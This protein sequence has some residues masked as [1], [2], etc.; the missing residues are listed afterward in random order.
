MIQRIDEW[1]ENNGKQFYVLV[2]VFY[3]FLA[4]LINLVRYNNFEV[5]VNYPELDYYRFKFHVAIVSSGV[6]PYSSQTYIY[7]N[8]ADSPVRYCYV[9]GYVVFNAIIQNLFSTTA[10][11]ATYV[12]SPL[13][14]S[15]LLPIIIYLFCK[16]M[17]FD[18]RKST[19]TLMLLIFFSDLA[20]YHLQHPKG[21]TMGLFLGLLAVAYHMKGKYFK[22]S[23]VFG[24]AFLFNIISGSFMIILSVKT[25]FV[26]IF[27][28]KQSPK[29][30]RMYGGVLLVW[31][32][33]L[34]VLTPYITPYEISWPDEQV[35]SI[36]VVVSLEDYGDKEIKYVVIT[37]SQMGRIITDDIDGTYGLPLLP[38]TTLGY[39][40]YLLHPYTQTYWGY[41]ARNQVE[42]FSNY[43]GISEI[44]LSP[45]SLD[46]VVIGIMLVLLSLGTPLIFTSL[47][48]AF[49]KIN[50][51]DRY[52][53][54]A[55]YL[56][57]VLSITFRMVCGWSLNTDRTHLFTL[58]VYICLLVKNLDLVRPWFKGLILIST[59]LFLAR[60]V[61][62]MF[63]MIIQGGSLSV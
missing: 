23:L 34:G 47:I 53:F 21:E 58:F 51:E 42:V 44:K 1:L 20:Y 6:S 16:T 15:I 28:K 27:S 31:V 18:W 11:F 25:F 36:G 45:F 29:N 54:F 48:S 52:L 41:A 55:A 19:Y 24:L 39:V 50:S 57:P 43:F 40:S 10:E 26:F 4:V 37:R 9:A 17:G 13:I 61:L 49:Y 33:F 7:N 62:S 59:P 2:S 35:E 14:M 3:V 32:V 56:L 46:V 8:L 5:I 63:L 38:T 22:S 12:L 30:Y 60:S